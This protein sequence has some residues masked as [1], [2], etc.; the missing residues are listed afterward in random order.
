[1]KKHLYITFG[2][3]GAGKSTVAQY[4]VD[5]LPGECVVHISADVMRKKLFPLPRYDKYASKTVWQACVN[6]VQKAMIEE[7]M[8]VWDAVF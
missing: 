4:L 2:L 5:I 6:A 8:I 1:M 7:K 3:P